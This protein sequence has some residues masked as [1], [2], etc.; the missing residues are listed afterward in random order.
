M[1]KKYIYKKNIFINFLNL[2]EIS[3]SLL[4]VQKN[5]K[6]ICHIL[7]VHI[8]SIFNFNFVYTFI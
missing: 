1:K 4:Y 2:S 8:L 7:N 3:L 5:V 6:M